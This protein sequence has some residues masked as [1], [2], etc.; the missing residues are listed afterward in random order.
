MTVKTQKLRLAAH[1]V[2]IEGDRDELTFKVS[3]HRKTKSGVWCSYE[4][5]LM[6]CRFAVT[7]LLREFKA[8]HVRDRARINEEFARITRELSEL[9]SD[10]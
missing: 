5:E 6:C 9:S 3:A 7:K 1:L 8:M 2:G 10:G 4:L